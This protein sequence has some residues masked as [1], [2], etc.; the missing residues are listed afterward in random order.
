MPDWPAID[1]FD[2]NEPRCRSRL[3]ELAFVAQEGWYELYRHKT[4]G[5]LWRIDVEDKY[6]QRFMVEIKDSASWHTFD[7]GPLQKQLLFGSRSGDSEQRCLVAGCQR[8]ALHGLAFCLEHAY[9]RGIR[10]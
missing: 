4:D 6:Q 9:E 2:S 8:H 3:D 1:Y 7:S 5:S 10:K